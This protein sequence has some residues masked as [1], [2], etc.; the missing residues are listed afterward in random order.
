MT[1]YSSLPPAFVTDLK[2]NIPTG[3]L[4]VATYGLGIFKTNLAGYC[5]NP[6]TPLTI[7][8]STTW[9][10]TQTIC[11]DVIVNSSLTITANQIMPQ[12]ATITVNSGGLLTVSAATVTNANIDVK[13]GGQL[14]VQ[15]GGRGELNKLQKIKIELGATSSLPQASVVL[16]AP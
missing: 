13:S 8:S 7:S 1:T 12:N 3:D 5:Y 15:S 16:M 14:V 6:S 11:Y 2:L 4:Y 10:T 9:S